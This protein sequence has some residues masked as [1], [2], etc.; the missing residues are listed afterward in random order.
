MWERLKHWN[1]RLGWWADRLLLLAV[2][3]LV[4]WIYAT[5]DGTAFTLSIPMMMGGTLGAASRVFPEKQYPRLGG[6]I[7]LLFIVNGITLMLGLW[8]LDF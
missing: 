7:K 6:V 1:A 8:F 4:V 2:P 3:P 5:S